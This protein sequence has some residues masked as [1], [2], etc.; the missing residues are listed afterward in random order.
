MLRRNLQLAGNVVFHQFLKEGL[1]LVQ[2]QIIV[3]DAAANEHLLHAGNGPKPPKDRK[4]IAVIHNQVRAGRRGQ[5][6]FAAL[7]HTP[8]HLLFAADDPEVCGGA[9]HIVDVP[10]KPGGRGNA[11]TLFHNAVGAA[12]GHPPPLMQSNGAEI[13]AAVTAAVL[14]DGKLHLFQAGHAAHRVVA[15]MGTAGKRQV[16]H[17]V[18][19]Q[20]VQGLCG[21]I[22]H[23]IPLPLLLHHR[24]AGHTVL[25]VHLNAAG[26]GVGHLV[27]AHPGKPGA[28]HIA[29]GQPG[30][31]RHVTGTRQVGDG[32]NALPGRQPV[33]NGHRLPLAHAKAD[34]IRAGI[35]H[36]AGQHRVH[37]VIVVGKPPQRSLQPAQNY[38][39]VRI[40]L[41]GQMGVHG[42]ATVRPFSGLSAGGVLIHRAGLLGHRIAR[43]HTVNIAAA[44]HKGILGAAIFFEAL[45]GG[46]IRLADVAH[47][48]ALCLQHT[49]DDGRAKAGMI[50]IGIT[51]HQHKIQ[52]I[53]AA[54]LHIRPAQGQKLMIQ[55][56]WLLLCFPAQISSGTGF[57][58]RAHI[59][60]HWVRLMS[61]CRGLAPSYGPMMCICSISSIMRAAR[62]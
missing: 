23:Q 5:A 59:S 51:G 62:A 55:F 1:V 50:H 44:D 14:H 43:H 30:K 28:F 35:L 7:T 46:E 53:P 52:L 42:G 61:T 18:Q 47:P 16:K 41:L 31:V 57:S 3:A 34:Q 45:T 13:A 56:H 39:A 19:F 21:R 33:G 58:A 40:G 26:L 9:A 37:P 10:L 27:G 54:G 11:L 25:L 8:G 6:L 32:G 17:F 48:I 4:I 29:G 2:N 38:R 60:S 49:A 36:N 22:L 15:G 12:A 24:L 20:P